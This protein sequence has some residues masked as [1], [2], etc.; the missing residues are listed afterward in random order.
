MG[1][2]GL[3]TDLSKS[4]TMVLGKC[5][6]PC[7]NEVNSNLE[8]TVLRYPNG[9]PYEA[10]VEK[11][12]RRQQK[13]T[14]SPNFG[15]RGMTL[16]RLLNQ[17]NTWYRKRQLAIVYKK[18]TPIQVVD[19][20]YP[21]RSQARIKEAYYRQASTTDYNGVYKGYYLDFEAKETKQK[22]RFPL[23]NLHKHQVEHMKAC[24]AAGGV[25]FTIF[26][27]STLDEAYLYPIEELD[28]DWQA[29]E[30][31]EYV[32]I[33]IERIQKFGFRLKSRWQP[34]LDYLPAVRQY[35]KQKEG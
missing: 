9:E 32:S 4:Q 30:A 20:A 2:I 27:F 24:H 33:P 1:K 3:E 7:Y 10:P 25:C 35:I 19:V 17:A 31:K 6:N 34:Q 28:V 23:S 21:K 14:S 11:E 22:T 12:R 26:L 29:Y 13:G 18:P 16:E 5:S 15:K 8:V